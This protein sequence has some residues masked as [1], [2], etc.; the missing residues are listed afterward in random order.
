MPDADRRVEL[1]GGREPPEREAGRVGAGL[2]IGL[3][4]GHRSILGAASGRVAF[5][6]GLLYFVATVLL[7]VGGVLALGVLYDRFAAAATAMATD[8]ET[9]SSEGSD[10]H[11][12][13]ADMGNR[14]GA[15]ENLGAGDREE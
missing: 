1:V 6:L 10:D 11:A 15:G 14:S 2:L 5:E 9:T 12:N 13:G 7:S 8:G 3:V 4:A